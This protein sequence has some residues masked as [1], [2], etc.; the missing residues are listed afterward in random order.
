VRE[1]EASL[2]IEAASRLSA[3]QNASGKELESALNHNR[4]LWTLLMSAVTNQ[5]NPLDAS[6][7]QNI[8]NIGLFVCK[9][10]LTAL[11]DP[12]PNK[13]F[14]LININRELA[15]GLLAR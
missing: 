13:L 10:T 6:I 5:E 11:A 2:L 4:R 14:P 7:R 8:A 9:H 15:A 12:R 3:A 1:I